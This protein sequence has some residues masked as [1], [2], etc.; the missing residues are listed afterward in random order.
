MDELLKLLAGA[1]MHLEA[2]EE[3][4]AEGANATASDEL[5]AAGEVLATLRGRWAEMSATERAVVGK[6]A[7]P[8]RARLDA[9][10]RRLPRRTALTDGAPEADPEQDADPES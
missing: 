9:A 7:A 3:A 8:L 6:T 1:S 10:Q 4:L 5:D 2:G